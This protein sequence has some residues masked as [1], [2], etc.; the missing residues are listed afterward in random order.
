MNK[1]ILDRQLLTMIQMTDDET[2]GKALRMYLGDLIDEEKPNF[3]DGET[4]L[5][6]MFFRFKTELGDGEE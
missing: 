6:M 3:D 5:L 2:V 1:L 4:N